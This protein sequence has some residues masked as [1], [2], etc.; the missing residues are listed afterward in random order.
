MQGDPDKI[1]GI[2]RKMQGN[3]G[4]EIHARYCESGRRH[5]EIW[6]HAELETKG[7]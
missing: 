4:C 1:Q 5:R 2:P 3:L 7:R 6:E